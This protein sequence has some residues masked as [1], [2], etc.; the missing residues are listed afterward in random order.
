MALED[1]IE[2]LKSEHA[3][4]ESAIQSEMARPLPNSEVLAELKRQKLRIKDELMRLD[5]P[6][7]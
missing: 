5:A 7:S 3:G 6:S 1:L 2:K 4:L